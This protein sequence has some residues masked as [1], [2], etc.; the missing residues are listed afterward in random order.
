MATIASFKVSRLAA[1]ASLP[2]PLAPRYRYHY[3][4]LLALLVPLIATIALMPPS[5]SLNYKVEGHA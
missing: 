4:L 1:A 3:P 5:L 2:V